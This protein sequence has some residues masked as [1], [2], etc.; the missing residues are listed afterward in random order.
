ML[1][2]LS[3][4]A[5]G[6][7][8]ADKQ[9]YAGGGI[10]AWDAD[11]PALGSSTLNLRSLEGLAGYNIF[12]WLA[13]EGRIGFGIESEREISYELTSAI[14][15]TGDT[16]GD[17]EIATADRIETNSKTD[18]NYYASL[19]VKP[20]VANDKAAL[21]GLIGITNYDISSDVTSSDVITSYLLVDQ[22]IGGE[23]VED[24]PVVTGN[25]VQGTPTAV[26]IDESEVA[27]SLGIGVS[28][29]FDDITVNA[30]WKN[31]VIGNDD[32]DTEASG[33]SA[34]ITYS[35]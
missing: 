29:F 19:L 1:I 7:Q 34:N 10:A 17:D 6:A 22:E 23:T 2:A 30:E 28:F 8:A 3:T 27:L 9:F 26:T 31:Y 32:T 12:P 21:Y 33:V 14:T 16:F 24:V 18:L 15:L 11:S 35:F 5:M 13:V 25:V 4:L 20:Q